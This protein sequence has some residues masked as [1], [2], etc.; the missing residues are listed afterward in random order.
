[1]GVFFLQLC[2]I[3]KKLTT[4]QK[5]CRFMKRFSLVIFSILLFF[6][7]QSQLDTKG[8]LLFEVSG[9]GLTNSSY[10]FGTFHI[11][12]KD[13]FS[14]SPSLAAKIVS[15]EQFYGELDMDDPSLQSSLM[16]KIMMKDKT[17]ES[18]M[19][20][21]SFKRF[22]EAFKKIT[23]FSAYQLNNYKPFFHLSLLTLKTIPCI[24]F[25]QPETELMQIAKKNGKEV[26]GLETV[27]EQMNAIDAQ[28]LDSQISSLQKMVLNFD[29]TKNMMKEMIT[30]YQKNDAE[31]L[32]EYVQ[33][34]GIDGINEEVLLVNR[35]KN[36][37]QKLKKIMQDKSSFIAVG[38]AHLGGKTGILALLRDA[39][40]IVKPVKY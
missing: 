27:E 38:G 3:F 20:S 14:I 29:S 9:N 31:L 22:D 21:V 1:M 12:C 13:Q 6:Y 4:N 32:Y 15:T 36:W 19:D 7:A 11:M 33:K 25:V 37:I 40:Y 39:G 23:G 5:Q 16:Q 35:N 28:P 18:L 10:I 2:N 26:L 24:N 30:V 17:I 8:S 34:Q